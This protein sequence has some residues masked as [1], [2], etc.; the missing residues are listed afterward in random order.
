MAMAMAMA[1]AMEAGIRRIPQDSAG[2]RRIPLRIVPRGTIYLFCV[3]NRT[4]AH[5]YCVALFRC[6]ICLSSII[7]DK[8]ANVLGVLII[9]VC[10]SLI[11]NEIKLQIIVDT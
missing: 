9:I 2:I 8:T 4:P 11:I 6:I 5:F 1:M 3:V 7:R 10:K